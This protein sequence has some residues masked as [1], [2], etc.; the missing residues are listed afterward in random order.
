[1]RV[2]FLVFVFFKIYYFM[3]M[4]VLPAC[5]HV[6][7]VNSWCLKRQVKGVRFPGTG[8]TRDFKPLCGQR[9]KPQSLERAESDLNH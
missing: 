4:S 7:F 5:L 2:A 1:V 3:W 8:I 6:H 9:T